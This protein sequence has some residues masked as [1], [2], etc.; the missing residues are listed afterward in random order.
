[1]MTYDIITEGYKMVLAVIV[2]NGE[3]GYGRPGL[4]K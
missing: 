4:I 3:R 2:L 1:M